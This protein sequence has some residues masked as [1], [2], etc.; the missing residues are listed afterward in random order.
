MAQH[1]R[2]RDKMSFDFS[3]VVKK[4][5]FTQQCTSEPSTYRRQSAGAGWIACDTSLVRFYRGDCAHLV[6]WTAS[7]YRG[8][9]NGRGSHYGNIVTDGAFCGPT[10]PFRVPGNAQIKDQLLGDRQSQVTLG[11]HNLAD[12]L[13]IAPELRPSRIPL[14]GLQF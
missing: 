4:I 13:C 2:G 8:Q 14:W 3:T 9:P 10:P 11:P 12:Q 5:F 7:N 6:L 1:S